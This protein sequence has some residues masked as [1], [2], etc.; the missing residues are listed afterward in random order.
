M[1]FEKEYLKEK[2]CQ[3]EAKRGLEEVKHGLEEVKHGLEEAKRTREVAKRGLE[4]A[5]FAREEAKRDLEEAKCAQEE[6]KR[7][8]KEA[9]RAQDKAIAKTIR[10]IE[11]AKHVI[12]EVKRATQF[13]TIPEL[14]D[15]YNKRSLIMNMEINPRVLTIGETTK[16]TGTKYPKRIIPW[17][18]FANHQQ[19][20]WN[21][22]CIFNLFKATL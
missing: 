10:A 19:N 8:L 22:L 15:L 4:K 14:L 20:I 13:T 5:K 7:G 2:H 12:E 11:K 16:P 3:E 17:I 6:A 18:T 1:D 9:K 21:N